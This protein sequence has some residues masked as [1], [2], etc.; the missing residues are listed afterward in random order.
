MF[1]VCVCVCKHVQINDSEKSGLQNV[2][3]KY[4]KCEGEA[5]VEGGEGWWSF[6]SVLPVGKVH[7]QLFLII[8]ELVWPIVV[9]SSY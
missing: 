6:G 5:W 7:L 1:H 2:Q 8:I 4:A 3:N 9:H